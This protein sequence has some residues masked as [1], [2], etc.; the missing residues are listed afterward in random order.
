MRSTSES[1]HHRL[2]T[3]KMTRQTTV[4]SSPG[5]FCF[6][7]T[8]SL[9]L[10]SVSFT[11]CI[12]LTA[13]GVPRAGPPNIS[14]RHFSFQ[15][16][17]PY[18]TVPTAVLETSTTSH[19]F[20]DEVEVTTKTNSQVVKTTST[21]SPSTPSPGTIITSDS[22]TLPSTP[23]SIDFA[24]EKYASATR[25]PVSSATKFPS[26]PTSSPTPPP[27]ST[28]TSSSGV[29]T[30]KHSLTDEHPSVYSYVVSSSEAKKLSTVQ[31]VEPPNQ[32]LNEAFDFYSL[33]YDEVR[34]LEL[35]CLSGFPG[36]EEHF[37]VGNIFQETCRINCTVLT[38]SHP[39][40]EG[41]PIYFDKSEVV[42]HAINEGNLCDAQNVS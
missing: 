40:R 21:P 41:E 19:F 27:T 38:T 1:R 26:Q 31:P 25:I 32:M 8:F 39:I 42:S 3:G 20:E 34:R 9:L 15:T 22:T 28:S 16:A 2:F 10:A 33:P 4:I 14:R 36:R 24:A 30:S 6:L 17:R 7:L 35:L 37:V 23:E 18:S 29:R 11:S 5:P 12:T 13:T